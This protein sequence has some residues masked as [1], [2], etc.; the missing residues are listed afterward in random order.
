MGSTITIRNID[1]G[2][3]SWLERQAR[4]VGVSLEEFVRGLIREKRMR[5]ERRMTPSEIFARHFGS[6]HG[7]ELPPPTRHSYNRIEFMDESGT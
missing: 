7:V 6:E 1:P 4:H 2:D 5:T 3:K